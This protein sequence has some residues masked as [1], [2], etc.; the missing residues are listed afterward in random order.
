MAQERPPIVYV[1]GFAGGTHGIEHVVDDPFYGFN[2]GS[3]HVRVDGED[4]AVFYSFEGPLLRLL[5]QEGYQLLVDGGQ[6]HYLQTHDQ[7]PAQS[8]WIHRFYD[9]AAGYADT[10]TDPVA[11]NIDPGASAT[12]A[13]TE[14]AVP[15]SIEAAALGLLELIETLQAKTSPQT[16]RVHLVAHSMGGLIVR[17]MIQK[18]IPDKRPGH[19]A[20]EYVDKIFTYA[21]PHAGISLALDGGVLENLRDV[22]HPFGT[23]IFVPRRMYEYLTPTAQSGNGPPDGW[24]AADLPDD[25]FPRE[26]VFCLV[27]TDSTDY[28]VA[29]GLSAL[30]V[31]SRSD[32]LVRIENA[33]IPGAPNAYVHR[34]HSG[35]FGVVNSEEGFQNLRRFLFGDLK[36]QA[37]LVGVKLPNEDPSLTWQ[38]EIR[39]SVRGLPVVTHERTTAHWCPIQLPVAPAGADGFE[40]PLATSFLRSDLDHHDES[41]TARYAVHLRVLSLQE[42]RGIFAF[43]EHIEQVFDVDDTLIIDLRR[44]DG[45]G[46]DAWAAWNSQIPAAVRDYDPQGM[47][48]PPLGDIDPNPD[49]WVSGIDLP[50]VAQAV[51]GDHSKV[52][53]TITP[54]S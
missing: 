54:W 43:R 50:P 29:L 45:G 48:T 6:R 31:G 42:H 20:E 41:N 25:V 9:T 22:L 49:S 2:E 5:E 26:R 33:Q 24:Y 32:G 13:W 35:R 1:R 38:A 28:G 46:I 18:V 47:G 19:S 39:V 51:L 44:A 12:G 34:S 52:R 17:C 15:Y 37:D 8:V 23:E 30:A 10:D 16:S 7:V 3:T 11:G 27:G 14:H 21:T 4:D 53:L 36:V 40:V